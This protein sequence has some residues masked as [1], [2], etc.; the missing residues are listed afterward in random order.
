MARPIDDPAQRHVLVIGGAGYVGSVLVRTLLRRGYRTRVLDRFL[1]RNSLS[2]EGLYDE[3]GFS[4]RHGD[5][6]S[7]QVVGPALEGITDVVL[8]ASLVGDPISKKY[9]E[10]TRRV[11]LDASQRLF[12]QLA[13]RDIDRF[14]FTS[15]CSNYGLLSSDAAATEETEL[16]PLSIYA[17]TKVAMEQFILSR[18]GD[19]AFAS[20]IL[21]IATAYGL[22]PRM[23]FDLTVNEFVYVLASGQPLQVYDKDTWR[24]YCHVRDITEAII[25][26]IEADRELVSGQ[27][28][29]VGNDE[30]NY[31]KAML[32]EEILKHVNGEVSFV[33]GSTDPRNYRVSFKKIRRTLDFQ[34]SHS[35]RSYI[36]ELIGAVRSGLFLREPEIRDY[37]GNYK[38]DG[39]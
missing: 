39:V 18:L 24:P 9:P 28:F 19:V 22:S 25:R 36:P 20:T 17:S 34:P 37:Y 7:D 15:T 23:R 16:N 32:V 6:G 11:N 12:E 4:L 29:N 26:V 8:L 38:I 33:E 3:D 31:T 5:L 1:Y 27:V 21:R 2:L 10:L 14:V 30:N 35:V 13:R